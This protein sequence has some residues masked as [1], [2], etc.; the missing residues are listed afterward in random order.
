[1]AQSDAILLD[2]TRVTVAGVGTVHLGT[3]QLDLV[4]TPKPKDAAFIS[5][6]HSVRVRGS[7]SHPDVSS[8]P[9]DIAMSAGWL[10]LGVVPPFGLAMGVA[11]GVASGLSKLGTGVDNPCELARAHP[12]GELIQP[13]QKSHG[14]LDRAQD[15]WDGFRGWLHKAFDGE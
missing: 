14:F 12:E 15:L 6:A 4:L 7:L 3:E 5:L 8:D 2:T 9:K 1:M 10:A 11:I 13:V